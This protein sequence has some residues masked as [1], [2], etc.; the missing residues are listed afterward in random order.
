MQKFEKLKIFAAEQK[1]LKKF[2]EIFLQWCKEFEK[3]EV[4]ASA[5]VHVFRIKSTIENP[6]NTILTESKGYKYK[7]NMNSQI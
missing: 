7:S 1:K 5:V 4:F 2:E 3:N 6:Q